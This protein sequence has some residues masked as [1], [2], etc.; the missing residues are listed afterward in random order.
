MASTTIDGEQ[1]SRTMDLVDEI[2]LKLAQADAICGVTA[3]ARDVVDADGLVPPALH[4]V[5]DLLDASREAFNE[6]LETV[7]KKTHT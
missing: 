3:M 6:L 4:A 5:R 7:I 2:K 1:W